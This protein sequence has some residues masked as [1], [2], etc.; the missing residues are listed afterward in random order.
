MFYKIPLIIL[1]TIMAILL[2]VYFS[3]YKPK[4]KVPANK[5]YKNIPGK[6]S[7]LFIKLRSKAGNLKE[8]IIGKGYNPEICF[9]I[10]M[11]IESGRNRFFVYD[12]K[13]DSVLLSG[14]VAHGSCDDGFKTNVT[15]SNEINSGCSS[16][17]KYKIGNAYYGRFGMAYKLYGLD[18][19][20]RNAFKRSVVLHSYDCVPEQEIY[21]LPICNSRGCAMISP[22]FMN[23]LKPVI[24]TSSKPVLLWIFQ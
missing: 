13:N 18:S 19:S 14:L 22:G 8:F 6:N 1:V 3:W 7:D 20:N 9:L 4:F 12:M 21:P 17:G 16:F 5:T 2:P 23:C 10:D 24:N 15:F 11:S